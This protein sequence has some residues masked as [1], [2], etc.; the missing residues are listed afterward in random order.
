MEEKVQSVVKKIKKEVEGLTLK[1]QLELVEKLVRQLREKG[2]AKK[3]YL[4]WGELYGLGKGLWDG[5]DAQE[6]VN[7]LRKDRE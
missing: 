4:D 7:R 1:E 5:E 3:E 6:Y 2:L